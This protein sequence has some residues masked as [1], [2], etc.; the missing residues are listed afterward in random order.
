[1]AHHKTSDYIPPD[2]LDVE[3][4]LTAFFLTAHPDGDIEAVLRHFA[5]QV[6]KIAKAEGCAPQ[7]EPHA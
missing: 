1:M 5:E 2:A 3:I 6:L 7:T 4:G